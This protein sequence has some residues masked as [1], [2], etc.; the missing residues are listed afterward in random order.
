MSKRI[1]RSTII[2]LIKC[3]VT[4]AASSLHT[5]VDYFPFTAQSTVVYSLLIT[6][7]PYIWEIPANPFAISKWKWDR[8]VK[9]AFF[10]MAGCA[11]ITSCW[12]ILQL[13]NTKSQSHFL[14]LWPLLPALMKTQPSSGPTAE[15]WIAL[16]I[17]WFLPPAVSYSPCECV[18]VCG[19]RGGGWVLARVGAEAVRRLCEPDASGFGQQP[20][21]KEV[22]L[23]A[24]LLL[25]PWR[26]RIDTNQDGASCWS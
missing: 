6:T 4:E 7:H 15:R 22:H 11:P 10:I 23:L 12:P 17:L 25:V 16:W 5:V 18:P 13:Q 19:A 20:E 26:G 9:R 2:S 8:G 3:L 14:F 21:E 24:L 1:K